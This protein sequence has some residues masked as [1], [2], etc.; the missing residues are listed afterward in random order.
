MNNY[1]AVLIPVISVALLVLF[2]WLF[3]KVVI[4]ILIASMLTLLAQPLV[5]FYSALKISGRG[6]PNTLVSLFTLLTMF[7]SIFLF[8]YITLPL[9]LD[10]TRFVATLNFNDVFKD[11]LNQFPQIKSVLMRFGSEDEI[12]KTIVHQF[13][14]LMD[15]NNVSALL[16][17][18]A[19]ITG[20]V[21]GGTLAVSFITFFLLKEN[22]MTYRTILLITPSKFEHE[23]K[24]ILRTTKTMLSKYFVAL[25]IDV[26]FVGTV[27]SLAMYLLGVNNAL[28]IGVITGMLNIIPYIGPLISFCIACF[29][30]ITGCIEFGL[31]HEIGIVLTKIFFVLL[32]V[33]LVDGLIVQPYLFSNSVKA[34]PLEIFLVILMAATV[35][36]IVGMIVAIPTY[37]LFRIIAKEFLNNY[38]F[39]QKMTENIPE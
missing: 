22:Q 32:G 36:G 39:F 28:F 37:T 8:F 35:G 29:F 26:V 6:L 1:K 15:L 27:V 38:K 17:E 20:T 11:I 3:T 14:T 30:G 5:K 16:N 23:M 12:A 2:V 13:N 18:F 25:V 19:S 10:E 4:Y 24:D 31:T 33:N 9:I 34:H 7:V 21:I